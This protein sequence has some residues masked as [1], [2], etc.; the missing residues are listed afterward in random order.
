MREVRDSRDLWL[1]GDDGP[2][3]RWMSYAELGSVRG[4]TIASAKRLTIRRRWRR[5]AGNDGTTR[6][7]VPL[8]ETA[9]RTGKAST[10]KDDV[11]ALISRLELALSALREQLECER[12]RADE[13]TEATRQ[14]AVQLAET[15]SQLNKLQAAAE[16]AALVRD[17]L[18]RA[19]RAEE[20]AN[21][22][23]ELMLAAERAA[24]DMAEA[25]ASTL[26]QAE[27][28]RRKL[29]PLDRLRTAWRGG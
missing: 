26:R 15:N 20:V 10:A 5:Q 2:A 27:E 22:E 17:S 28:A 4:I 16:M 23:A 12:S 21:A 3:I 6:V 29:G 25:D 19:L 13:A 9:P 14:M 11:A 8:E 7:A 18:E 24:K 1:I